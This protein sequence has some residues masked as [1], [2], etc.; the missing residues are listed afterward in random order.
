[1]VSVSFDTKLAP[2]VKIPKRKE[3]D[4]EEEVHGTGSLSTLESSYCCLDTAKVTFLS[5][6]F[7]LSFFLAILSF[8]SFE[9]LLPFE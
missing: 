5:G 2:A 1:M 8:E 9:G 4:E 6:D 7:L 3:D